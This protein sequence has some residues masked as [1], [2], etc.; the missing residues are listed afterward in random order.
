MWII[1][2][3]GASLL[4]GMTY[5]LTEQIY[6]KISVVTTL[7][8]SSLI[9]TIVMLLW[10]YWGGYLKKDLATISGSNHLMW[11]LVAE[12]VVLIGAE[13]LIGLSIV[14]KNATLAGLIEISYPIFIALFAYLLFRENQLN[15]GTIIG[16]IIIFIG[17]GMIYWFNK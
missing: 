13:L 10:A 3:I 6:K 7:G 2:A 8:I 16:G 12:A 11:L 14:E 5:V 4:W 17:V 15:T 1:Y 9:T